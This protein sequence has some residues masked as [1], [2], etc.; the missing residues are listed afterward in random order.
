[1]VTVEQ[2]LMDARQLP[3]TEQLRLLE[4][5]A[6]EIRVTASFV[7]H[8][9]WEEFVDYTAGILADDPIEFMEHSNRPS[10]S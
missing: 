7:H 2:L 4:G 5:L 6:A 10:S 8:L 9:S 1:M 3:V